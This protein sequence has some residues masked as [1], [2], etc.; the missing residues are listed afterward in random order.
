MSEWNEVLNGLIDRIEL[1]AEETDQSV[2]ELFEGA[3]DEYAFSIHE[4]LLLPLLA[5]EEANLLADGARPA[6]RYD[7]DNGVFVV[8]VGDLKL[9][10]IP[11]EEC[12]KGNW[13]LLEELYYE[14]TEF[15]H[16]SKLLWPGDTSDAR[17]GSYHY[18]MHLAG[19]AVLDGIDYGD[20]AIETFDGRVHAWRLAEANELFAKAYDHARERDNEALLDHCVSTALDLFW[21]DEDQWEAIYDDVA[22]G[23]EP[24]TALITRK[25]KDFYVVP[26]CTGSVEM[27]EPLADLACAY[28]DGA[29]FQVPLDRWLKHVVNPAVLREAKEV[30]A[31][32][33]RMFAG[34]AADVAEL[35]WDRVEESDE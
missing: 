11:V 32:L 4:A 1:V 14:D 29:S 17:A 31:R 10:D 33:E 2:P 21:D 25:G 13:E 35:Y 6:V 23:R 18:Y 3:L 19:E 28:E 27:V 9:F 26:R 22:K 15:E 7:A 8:S 30:V 34:V 5:A 20:F 16:D 24:L 12:V